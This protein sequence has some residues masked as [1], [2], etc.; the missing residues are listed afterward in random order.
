[1]QYNQKLLAIDEVV[2]S[3]RSQNVL[4]SIYDYSKVKLNISLKNNDDCVRLFSS[5]VSNLISEM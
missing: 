5:F 4:C 1:L 2:C 3:L